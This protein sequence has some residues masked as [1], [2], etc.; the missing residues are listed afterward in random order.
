MYQYL[1]HIKVEQKILNET[2]ES[3]LNGKLDVRMISN[4]HDMNRELTANVNRLAKRMAKMTY[5]KEEDEQTIKILTNNITSPIIYIDIDG[6]IRYVNNQFINLFQVTI[7]INDIYEKIRVKKLYKFIDDA[8]ILETRQIITSQIGERYYQANA[9]PINNHQQ[10]FVGILFIFHDV[11]EIKKYEKLQREFLADASHELKTP[12]SAIKGASEILLNGEYHSKETF[13]DFLTII[14]NENER[15]ERIVRDIL[16]ISR[17]ESDNILIQTKK[18]DIEE[19]MHNCIEIMQFKAELKNQTI[20]VDLSPGLFIEG[21][22]DRLKHAFLNLISNAI[23]YT[24]ES[25]EIEVRSY[26]EENKVKVS[27]KD[28]GI[29]IEPSELKHIFERFYRIDKARSRET[30]GTGLGLAIVKSTF[31]VHKATINVRSIIN[32]GT[33]FVIAFKP[34]NS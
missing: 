14:K 29:G 31:D 20:K 4:G 17:L 3:L 24:N 12:L 25:K 26:I 32:E 16:L 8:F 22:Y 34:Y 15:M 19:L 7:E 5:K 18:V 33:H 10:M 28:E 27:I 30:G 11:T 1:H 9:I 23:N 13:T 2:I 6:R 21:D